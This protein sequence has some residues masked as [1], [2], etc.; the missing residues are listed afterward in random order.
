MK[1]TER[2]SRMDANTLLYNFTVE[3]PTVWTA[4]FTGEY[5]WP[6]SDN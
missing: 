1:V 6:Q 3:D 4:P 2:F 5:A